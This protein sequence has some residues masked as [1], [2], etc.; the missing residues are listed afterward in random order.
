MRRPPVIL[1]RG[2]RPS[3]V[4]RADRFYAD[5]FGV[6]GRNQVWEDEQVR[7]APES[8]PPPKGSA[9]AYFFSG[10]QYLRY[11]VARDRVDVN[12]RAIAGAWRL[13]ERFQSH[14]DASVNWGEGHAYLF[15]GA[16]YVRYNIATDRVDV[17]PI[18][19]AANWTRLPARFQSNLDA[20]VNWGNGYA[21]FFKDDSYLGYHIANDVVDV[22]PETIARGWPTLPAHFRN[23]L[24]AVVNWGNGRAYFFKGTDYVRMDTGSRAI[25]VAQTAIAR[26]W[27]AL[28]PGFQRNIKAAINWT[29]PC[30]LAGLLR[31]AGVTTVESQGW[32]TRQ[33]SGQN[34]CF[35][36]VG[37]IMHHTVGVGPNALTDI[38]NNVKANFFVS[39]AGEVTVVSGGRANHA[40]MGAQEVLDEVTRSVA[41]AGTAAARS[42]ADRI[43]GNGHFYGFENENKGDGVQPW[44]EVQLDAM[45]RGAAALCQRHCWNENRVIAHAEWTSRK[46]DPRGVDMNAF[47]A[48]VRSHF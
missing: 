4:R 25:D 35:T 16:D 45:A 3:E 33:S 24:D 23:N 10:A 8:C 18:A 30:D 41:P 22:G 28:P 44:P 43:T 34:G 39:R 13:P 17:G 15:K 2:P 36:P 42:L 7:A 5:L 27:T 29:Y 19:I 14:L 1:F 12:P 48:R 26:N 31:A 20:A 37:I 11:D 47:R 46:I 38:V 32:Q 40:G 6:T 21:Y 9:C